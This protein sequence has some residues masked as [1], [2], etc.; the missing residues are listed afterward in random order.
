[1]IKINKTKKTVQLKKNKTLSDI[2]MR[3]Q[4][5]EKKAINLQATTINE[6]TNECVK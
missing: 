4:K 5:R 2:L 6:Q 1:M 3:V